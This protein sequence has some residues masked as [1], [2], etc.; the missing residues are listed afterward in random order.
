VATQAVPTESQRS[1]PAL[2]RSH[3]LGVFVDVEFSA[4]LLNLRMS[5]YRLKFNF[6]TGRDGPVAAVWYMYDGA[7]I[8]YGSG[9]TRDNLQTYLSGIN[10]E[11]HERPREQ[12]TSIDIPQVLYERAIVEGHRFFDELEKPRN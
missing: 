5:P 1:S 3:S 12:D 4:R 6:V 2:A 10:H 8:H 9:V 7:V 11:L